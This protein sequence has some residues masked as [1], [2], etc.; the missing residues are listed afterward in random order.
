MNSGKD[1]RKGHEGSESCHL[2]VRAGLVC[3]KRLNHLEPRQ[4][5]GNTN[6]VPAADIL[7][8][9]TVRNASAGFLA[10]PSFPTGLQASQADGNHSGGTAPDFHRISLNGAKAA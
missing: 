2:Y 4:L 6:F 1:D 5:S 9:I 3:S 8:P 10:Y 7:V